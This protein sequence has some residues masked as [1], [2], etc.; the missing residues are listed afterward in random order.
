MLPNA[1]VCGDGVVG[2]GE[3]CDDG[4]TQGCDG[5]SPTCR[6]EGCGNA[7]ID[8]DEQC[9]AGVPNPPPA[10]GCTARC[11]ALPPAL[12]IPGGGGRPLDC[13]QE[14]SLVLDESR[15]TRD[16]RGV[17][18]NRQD[19]VDG[20]PRCDSNAASGAC[21]LQLFTCV[22]GA[23]ARLGCP[24]AGIAG[25]DVL[26]PTVSDPGPLRDTLVAALAELGLPTSPG[27]VCTRGHMPAGKKGMVLKLR[28]R[29]ASGKQ[30]RDALKLRC[31][32]A[33]AP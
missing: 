13:A 21:R 30:D 22:G 4:N 1:A 3:D 29:L 19:C 27:E 31:L 5:C 6:F 15:V 23:D 10:T 25:V 17:P 11:T 9:D 33:P 26:R 28:T 32:P 16:G 8:C 18:R 20:D 14:W 24:A 12:R 2:L 7:R